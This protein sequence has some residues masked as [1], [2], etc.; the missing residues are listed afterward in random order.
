MTDGDDCHQNALAERVNGIS[1]KEFLFL[2]PDELAQARLLVDQAVYLYNEERPHLALNY[3]T[4]NQVH[5]QAKAPPENPDGALALFLS[6][7]TRTRLLGWRRRGLFA[8]CEP[9]AVGVY[10]LAQHGQQGAVALAGF[11]R[12]FQLLKAGINQFRKIFDGVNAFRR[13]GH[14]RNNKRLRAI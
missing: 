2:L 14:G 10:L 5:Q 1:K 8:A 4:L 6:T 13:G 7:N 11:L 9:L 12:A 3:L